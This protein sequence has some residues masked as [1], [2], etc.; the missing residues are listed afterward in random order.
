[1]FRELKMIS[2]EN[3]PD[4]YPAGQGGKSVVVGS[5]LAE[6]KGAKVGQTITIS[7]EPYHIVGIFKTSQDIE[8]GMVIMYLGDAQKALGKIGMMTGCT[9]KAKDTSE[10]G[11]AAI[12]P[13]SRAPSPMPAA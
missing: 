1:M 8:N 12:R 6:V 11:I 4:Q 13:R 10:A 3:L 5:T 7:D 9:V 2:G